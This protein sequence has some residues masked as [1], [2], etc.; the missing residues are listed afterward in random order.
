MYYLQC[1]VREGASEGFQ[2]RVKNMLEVGFCYQTIF[3]RPRCYCKEVIYFDNKTI[4]KG[5]PLEK[6]NRSFPNM[7]YLLPQPQ[8]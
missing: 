7:F 5:G 2:V 8:L 1:S 6:V 3:K 4:H